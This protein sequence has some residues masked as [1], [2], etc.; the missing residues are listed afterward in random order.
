MAFVLAFY[1]LKAFLI[2]YLS[3]S[4]LRDMVSNQEAVDL[5]AETLST[6]TLNASSWFES[7]GLQ[8]AAEALTLESYVRGSKDNIG[9]AVIAIIDDEDATD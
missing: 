3:I 2:R 9:V 1:N 4:G 8:Q 5:V 7:S 6:A